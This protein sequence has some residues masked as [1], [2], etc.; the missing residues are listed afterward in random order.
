MK[1]L[2]KIT[3]WKRLHMIDNSCLLVSNVLYHQLVDTIWNHNQLLGMSY[4]HGRG[5][6]AF[7]HVWIVHVEVLIGCDGAYSIIAKSLQLKD[8]K[9]FPI[10]VV[11]G[12]TSYQSSHDFGNSFRRLRVKNAVFGIIPINNKLVHWFNGMLCSPEGKL[13]YI[14]PLFED[15][16]DSKW[17]VCYWLE[18]IPI[19]WLFPGSQVHKR[20]GTWFCERIPWRGDWY[21]EALRPWFTKRLPYSLPASMALADWSVLQWHDHRCRRRNACDGAIPWPRRFCMHGRCY[22]SGKMSNTRNA[23]GG[24]CSQRA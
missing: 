24:G 22:C 4:F 15:I 1:W 10:A 19:R 18:E 6:Y 9:I 14:E 7:E 16:S 12:F 17:M 5:T 2:L 11:R 13:I 20:L 3:Q 21:C 8:A 23:S